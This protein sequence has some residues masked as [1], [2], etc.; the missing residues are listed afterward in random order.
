LRGDSSSAGTGR[1]TPAPAVTTFPLWALRSLVVFPGAFAE[2]MLA[3]WLPWSITQATLHTP[4]LGPVSAALIAAAIA[5][6]LCA[7]L[8]N[9]HLGSRR[10]TIWMAL[11]ATLCLVA[12]AALWL[13][14]SP[15]LAC[16]FALAAIAADGAGDVG[17]SNL[18]P[19]IARLSRLPL[20]KF[21]AA[22]W[23]WTIFGAALGGV[24][25]G[26]GLQSQSITSLLLALIA[27]SGIVVVGL[28]CLV[29]RSR[30]R[31]RL[32]PSAGWAAM[33]SGALWKP[34]TVAVCLAI[35]ALGFVFGP[36][37]NLLVPAHLAGEGRS[38]A[39]FGNL[40]AA[41]GLGLAAGL[42]VMQF[43]HTRT[44]RRRLLVVT[45]AQIGVAL[46]IGF[47]WWL[48][49]DALL[50]SGVFLAA[51]MLAPLLPMLD[52]AVLTSTGIE[53]RALLIALVGTLSSVSDM[54]G[55]ATFGA[56]VSRVGSGA[57][58]AICFM[59]TCVALMAFPFLVGR[60]I[61]KRAI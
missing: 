38:A 7:P 32:P 53:H 11:T 24:F 13:A 52:A 30:Q 55:T 8:L 4:W 37:D 16:L 51:A 44:V 18:T 9:R 42:A 57:A 47:I 17:F 22:N 15:G 45:V 50:L 5:G 36:M 21:T 19:L 25:A 46:Y 58:L 60:R 43:M 31:G 28:A 20:A 59:L 1:R 3:V 14:S 27:S 35:F 26:W 41:G 56:V 40:I 10:M 39:T 34:G 33:F 49:D 23:L 61:Q 48:P 54:L 6:T 2:G 29:P 12:A